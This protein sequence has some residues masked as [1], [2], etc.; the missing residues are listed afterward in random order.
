MTAVD[1][2]LL[3]AVD[4]SYSI[5]GSEF[6]LQ[7]DG[8]AAAFRDPAVRAAITA[9]PE[10]A[11]AVAVMEWSGGSSQFMVVP[12]TRVD[13][14]GAA[15]GLAASITAAT[16]QTAEGATSLG[17]ALRGGLRLHQGSPFAAHRRVIDVS[18][19]GRH[20]EGPPLDGARRAVLEAGI[21]VNGL[22]I[23]REVA[24]LDRYFEARLIGGPGA[25]VERVEDYGGF[26]AA[27]RRKLLRELAPPGTAGAGPQVW[28]RSST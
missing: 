5:G 24:T 21:T 6:R 14:A 19:D 23:T 1:L 15:E 17:G 13:G 28:K 2:A 18:G 9:G 4:C 11:T 10:A 16:R 22:A 8:L 20:N 25:F 12:W 26:A 27:I 3:L 7:L